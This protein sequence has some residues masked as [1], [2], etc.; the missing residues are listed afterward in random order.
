MCD[1]LKFIDSRQIREYNKDTYFTP[2]EWSLIVARSVTTSVEEKIEALRYLA[3]H[4]GEAD[5]AKQSANVGPNRPVYH[6]NLPSR[7]NVRETIRIW[8]ETLEERYHSEG[9]VFAAKYGHKERYWNRETGKYQFFPDYSKAF[10]YLE[11]A[12]D[13]MREKDDFRKEDFF[14]E[15]YRIELG[16]MRDEDSYIFDGD[17]CMVEVFPLYKRC[18]TEDGERIERLDDS[19]DTVFIPLPF[20]KGDIIKV[21]SSRRLP[22]YGVMCC[23]WQPTRQDREAYMWLPLETYDAECRDFDY[24][25]GGCCDVLRGAVC[26]EEELPEKE[27]MLKKI[28]AVYKGEMGWFEL[29]CR[30]SKKE[31]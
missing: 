19:D 5:F 21:E 13:K 1:L 27:Q 9:V 3:G 11:E 14:G 24:M 23:D 20:K 26:P 31:I 18:V 12:R 6:R 17:L 2:A 28:S 8:E 30:F 16:D 15:I 10:L 4:Y 22:Y 25:D 29:L 7:E